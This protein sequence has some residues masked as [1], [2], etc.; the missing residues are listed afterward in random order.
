M[1]TR[2]AVCNRALV[3]IGEAPLQSEVADGAEAVLLLYDSAVETA[4]GLGDFSFATAI[5]Q[6]SR[7]AIKPK[8]RWLYRFQLPA[9]SLEG[10]KA[11]FDREDG[12]IP[13]TGWELF[14]DGIYTDTETLWAKVRIAPSPQLWTPLFTEGVV[15]Y[16]ASLLAGSMKENLDAASTLYAQAMG[17]PRVP[18]DMG[19]IGRA[20]AR[21]T[22]SQPSSRL[23]TTTASPLIAARR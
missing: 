17:D 3:R 16:L 10:P 8:G 22:A 15:V 9:E 11:I 19:L 23:M 6:L 21:D 12:T 14:D 1:V 7:D 13:F 5:R 4:L 18:G 2:I 20:R